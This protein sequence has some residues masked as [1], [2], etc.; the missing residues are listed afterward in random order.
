MTGPLAA[1]TGPISL[2]TGPDGTPSLRQRFDPRRNNLTLLRLGLAVAVLLSHAE[3]VRTGVRAGDLHVAAGELAVAAFFVL[4]GFLVAGSARRLGSVR[5]FLW[6]RALRI[7]PGFWMSLLVVAGIVAPLLA[8]L[9][10]RPPLS[11]LDGPDSAPGFVVRNA[12]L[13]VRQ[14][15]IGVPDAVHTGDTVLNGSLWSLYYEAA[16]YVVVA[17]F[18]SAGVMRLRGAHCGGHRRG[19]AL[20]LD[21]RREVLAAATLVTWLTLLVD[22][23]GPVLPLDKGRTLLFMFL[24]GVLAELYADHV[25][26]D[27]RIALGAVAVVVVGGGFTGEHELIG[28]PALAYALLWVSAAA[29]VP[30]QPTGDLSYGVYVYHWP[31]Q[32]VL[33]AL[34]LDALGELA[35]ALTSLAL[36]LLVAVASW[37]WV[38]RPALAHRNA[39]WVTFSLR[40]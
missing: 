28:A 15:R 18:M 7:L 22:A 40:A 14:W 1:M 10:G 19:L 33:V 4:S 24:V 30:V 16:C 39:R 12:L 25:P 26:M 8:A 11:V 13:L 21:H 2:R 31:L 38:E 5:R 32:L 37:V 27:G 34:G 29:P 6:H 9:G 35:F 17:L 20:V 23:I 3:R 36:T